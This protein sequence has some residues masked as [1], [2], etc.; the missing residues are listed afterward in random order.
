MR[1]ADVSLPVRNPIDSELL[2]YLLLRKL[3]NSHWQPCTV[4]GSELLVY[5]LLRKLTNFHCQ[6]C[7][8]L[9]SSFQLVHYKA[10]KLTCYSKDRH[11]QYSHSGRV[12]LPKGQLLGST[13]EQ[14]NDL[15][16]RAKVWLHHDNYCE[17]IAFSHELKP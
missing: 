10:L 4:G 3:T 2:V 7:T 5:L 16:L 13:P 15:T 12:I 11:D 17:I 8:C 9:T 1:N 6:P 14:L